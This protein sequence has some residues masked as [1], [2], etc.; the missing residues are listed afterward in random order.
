MPMTSN[1]KIDISQPHRCFLKEF[2]DKPGPCP[3]CGGELQQS[4]QSYLVVNQHK[5]QYKDSFMIGGDFGWFCA[6]CR[7][8]VLNPSDIEDHTGFTTGR[9][10]SNSGDEFAVLGIVNLGAVPHSKREAP[11]GDEDNP[12]PLVEFSDLT[13]IAP[14]PKSK[15]R[16]LR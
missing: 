7:I 3:Q 13:D 15:G 14:R 11:L 2:Q 16:R 12:I 9:G 6:N 5:G 10:N 1:K 8:V 4:Y